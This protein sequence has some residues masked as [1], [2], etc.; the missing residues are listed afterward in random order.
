MSGAIAAAE[1]VVEG[2]A[3]IAAGGFAKL[4]WIIA[5]AMTLVGAAGAGAGLW[6]RSEWK[7]CEASVAL[8][9]NKAE[10]KLRAA[11][12]ADAALRNRI[13]AQL[14]PIVKQLEDQANA[15][16]VALAKVPSDPSCAHTRAADAYDGS[17]RPERRQQADPGKPRSARP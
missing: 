10:E 7:A 11:Q 13:E 17:V 14:A 9:A 4:P 15:T 5:G 3:K 6:Y 8:D 16:Q 12:A 2:G 1:A